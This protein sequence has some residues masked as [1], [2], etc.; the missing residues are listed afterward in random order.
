MAVTDYSASPDEQA[1]AIIEAVA[2][3]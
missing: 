2:I 3:P 1:R